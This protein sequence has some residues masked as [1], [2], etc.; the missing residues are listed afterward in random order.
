[1]LSPAPFLPYVTYGHVLD[2]MCDA[3]MILVR[4]IS[5][6]MKQRTEPPPIT[7]ETMLRQFAL[8]SAHVRRAIMVSRHL[9]SRGSL[10]RAPKIGLL[11]TLDIVLGVLSEHK[12]DV[13]TYNGD[14]DYI[15]D[16]EED[17]FSDIPGRRPVTLIAEL[18]RDIGMVAHAVPA[19]WLT[20]IPTEFRLLAARAAAAA[21]RPSNPA[22]RIG[23][24]ME[25]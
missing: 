2:G 4:R 3:S 16:A 20:N 11:Q 10:G 13:E 1:M 15:L 5:E 24:L 12:I 21:I 18:L 22:A 8:L 9:E 19:E 7:Y 17:D 25:R 14:M 6:E 23:H